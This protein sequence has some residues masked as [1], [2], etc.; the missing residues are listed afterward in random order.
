MRRPRTD[1][2]VAG[3][4]AISGQPHGEP[5]FAC[6]RIPDEKYLGIRILNLSCHWLQRSRGPRPSIL[7]EKLRKVP[8]EDVAFAIPRDG[9]V[10][11]LYPHHTIDGSDM[12]GKHMNAIAG[13]QIPEPH[14]V[15]IGSGEGT[16]AAGAPLYCLY[17]ISVA[18]QNAKAPTALYVPQSNGSI[19]RARYRQTLVSTP[20]DAKDSPGVTLEN[21]NAD[22]PF[23]IPQAYG[24][25]Q[26]TRD[27]APAIIA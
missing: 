22:A 20:C 6:A 3:L 8:I 21:A 27:S 12:T 7:N 25:V 23:Q 15:V 16:M 4:P 5:G 17:V 13:I 24:S 2:R 14:R 11:V 26:A 1:R 19:L 18:F 9:T 10:A